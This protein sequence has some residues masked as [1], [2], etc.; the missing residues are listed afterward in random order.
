MNRTHDDSGALRQ[1]RVRSRGKLS[2]YCRKVAIESAV[3]GGGVRSR[4]VTV[5]VTVIKRI[6]TDLQVCWL[7][8]ENEMRALICRKV[9]W[10]TSHSNKVTTR[11][12]QVWLN[13]ENDGRRHLGNSKDSGQTSHRIEACNGQNRWWMNKDNQVKEE[14][15]RIEIISQKGSCVNTKITG[16][17]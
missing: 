12:K 17:D 5:G 1:E 14:V 9:G 13:G 16:S 11:G 4:T 8:R 15:Q 10:L 6:W 2:E 3:R 7:I